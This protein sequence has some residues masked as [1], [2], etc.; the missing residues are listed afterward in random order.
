MFSLYNELHR[1]MFESI[2]AIIL[3]SAESL[4]ATGAALFCSHGRVQSNSGSS[5]INNGLSAGLVDGVALSLLAPAAAALIPEVDFECELIRVA[6]EDEKV[7]SPL[8]LFDGLEG[9]ALT[10]PLTLTDVDVRAVED[11]VTPPLTA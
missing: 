5:G 3:S 7:T 9:A 10:P 6:A 1:N 8:D 11:C 4:I 2:W